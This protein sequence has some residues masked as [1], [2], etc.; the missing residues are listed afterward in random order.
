MF[1]V[2]ARD[3]DIKSYIDT[4]RIVYL[5]SVLPVDCST[6]HRREMK[7]SSATMKQTPQ[8]ATHQ[9]QINIVFFFN[10][11]HIIMLRKFFSEVG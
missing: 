1:H 10:I 7:T 5:I 3:R 11:G 2:T 6:D 4:S 8:Q 9:I